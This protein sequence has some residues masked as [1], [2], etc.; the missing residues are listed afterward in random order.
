MR[1]S[2]A[3]L[4]CVG[5]LVA[6]VLAPALLESQDRSPTGPA[7]AKTP[8]RPTPDPTPAAL[9]AWTRELD[10]DEFLTRETAMLRLLEAG[11]AALPA[12]TEALEGGSLEATSR[13]LYIVHQLGLSADVETQDAAWEALVEVAGRKETPNVA[14]RASATLAELRRERS[15]QA[16]AELEVLG[17]KI[18]LFARQFDEPLVSLELGDAFQGTEQDLR[19]LKWIDDVPVVVLSGKKVTASWVKY[20]AAMPG[21]TELHLYQAPVSDESLAV[22]ADHP[23]LEEIGLYYTRVGDAVL[24]PLAKVQRLSC[25]KLY[26]TRISRGAVE[27]FEE[28]TGLTRIDHRAGAFLGVGGGGIDGACLISTVHAGSPAEK[29]GLLQE[30][31][32]VGFGK[33]KVDSF[34]ALT[35]LIS[36]RDAGEEVEIEVLRQS[37]DDAG[38]S[39]LRTV[40]TK[41][42]L[43]PWQL[44]VAMKNVVPR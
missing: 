42:T 11:P 28:A 6:L 34:E 30:D 43:G 25:L 26:G 31:V 2:A 1:I 37:V 36:F 12:V 7:K 38:N 9:A 27:R 21:T 22:L 32:I 35:N 14:R 16:K 24:D 23:T 17:A 3:P 13:A 8:D 5:A 40:A 44:D 15:I 19:R 41:A 4:L 20:A 33:D 10:A 18:Q 39:V 29:A